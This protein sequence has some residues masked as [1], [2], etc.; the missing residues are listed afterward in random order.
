MADINASWGMIISIYKAYIKIGEQVSRKIK[1]SSANRFQLK[2]ETKN[3][4][5]PGNWF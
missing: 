1:I 2:T 5:N 3:L 4:P